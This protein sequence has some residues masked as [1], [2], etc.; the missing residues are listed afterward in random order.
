M[1]THQAT[2]QCAGSADLQST[3]LEADGTRR[4]AFIPGGRCVGM[5]VPPEATGRRANDSVCGLDWQPCHHLQTLCGPGYRDT[6]RAG[7]QRWACCWLRDP[8]SVAPSKTAWL[9]GTGV[10]TRR[11]SMRS[12]HWQ[13]QATPTAS[14]N[15]ACCIQRA[16][17]SVQVPGKHIVGWFR[18][19]F[20][21]KCKPSPIWEMHFM[22]VG[23]FHR[24]CSRPMH[25]TVWRPARATVWPQRTGT[26]LPA[27]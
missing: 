13:P 20:G 18:L 4:L 21:D 11:H 10:T 8:L 3:H 6:H 24:T 19:R 25:G 14:S 2:T 17:V 16:E 22:L 9:P 7:A 1:A 23:W 26:L 5:R 27:N 15:L 12:N